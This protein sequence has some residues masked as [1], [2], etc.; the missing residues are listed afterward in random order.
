MDALLSET[1]L[2][3]EEVTVCEDTVS[4]LSEV[5]LNLPAMQVNLAADLPCRFSNLQQTWR[6]MTSL[7]SVSILTARHDRS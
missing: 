5:L 7:E 4:T 1:C 3:P 2:L 6:C